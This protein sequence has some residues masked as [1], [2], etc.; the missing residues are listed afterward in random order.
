MRRR[1][2]RRSSDSGPPSTAAT[3]RVSRWNRLR[4]DAFKVF[5]E[6][7]DD[8][9]AISVPNYLRTF[10]NAVTPVTN[11]VPTAAASEIEH[12]PSGQNQGRVAPYPS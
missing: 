11:G 8:N 4:S 12:T 7:T 5:I 6:I 10:V 3:S 1:S 2:S 9:F